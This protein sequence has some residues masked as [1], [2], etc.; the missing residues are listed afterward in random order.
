MPDNN[1]EKR[2]QEQMEGFRLQ[3]SEQVWSEVELRIRKK[4]D[5]RRIIFWWLVPALLTGGGIFTAVKFLNNGDKKMLSANEIIKASENENIITEI[6]AKPETGAT[7]R[8]N[9][10]ITDPELPKKKMPNSS[11]TANS[12]NFDRP[13]IAT[14]TRK[15]DNTSQKIFLNEQEPFLKD[16]VINKK[17]I[18]VDNN[19]NTDSDFNMSVTDPVVKKEN[20]KK[21]DAKP[22]PVEKPATELVVINNSIK[23]EINN[24]QAVAE[25]EKTQ[26]AAIS[27]DSAASDKISTQNIAGQKTE[28]DSGTAPAAPKA[29]VKLKKKWQFGFSFE[30][31][32]SD[33]RASLIPGTG[34]NTQKSALAVFQAPPLYNGGVV[35]IPGAAEERRGAA[36]SVKAFMQKNI[37]RRLDIQTGISYSY[38]STVTNV[39]NRVNIPTALNYV[40]QDVRFLSG[41]YNAAYTAAA[42]SVKNDYINHYHLA[43]LYGQLNWRV[44]NWKKKAAIYWNNGLSIN[45]LFSSDALIFNQTGSVYYKDFNAF[46]K[47]MAGISSALSFRFYNTSKLSITTGPFIQYYL[48]PQLKDAGTDNKHFRN[49]GINMQILF[50]K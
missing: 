17:G 18:A 15:K 39:G 7:V 42:S 11:I 29:V 24:K 43:G 40:A 23:P 1:F 46:Q 22:V 3:P 35:I 6:E 21:A 41:F 47:Q 4:K 34:S 50:K 33:L 5:R 25:P 36:F 30:A 16:A 10:T 9:K 32:A 14:A 28:A 26:T 2:L 48:T 12:V 20:E 45:Q 27:N 8:E 44:T 13:L 19:K 37:R 49:Y 38:F 31:G